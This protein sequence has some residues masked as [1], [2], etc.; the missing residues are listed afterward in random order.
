M[1]NYY[2]LILIIQF[3]ILPCNVSAIE[4]PEKLA[5]EASIVEHLN[6][7]VDLSRSFTDEFGKTVTIL[8]LFL[9]DRP[10]IIVPVYFQCPRLCNYTLDGVTKLLGDL[11]LVLGK[12]YSVAIVSFNSRETSLDA[13]KRATKYKNSINTSDQAKKA[14][15]F[16]TGTEENVQGIMHELGFSF[17]KDKEEFAH[18][19]VFMVLTPNGKISRYFYGIQYKPRDVRLALVEAA[20]G[21]IGSTLER[22]FLYCFHFDALRGKYT[23]VAMNL[24][25]VVSLSVLGILVATLIILKLK[26]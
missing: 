9:K 13:H 22:V 19:A 3:L 8:E 5:E 16:L 17:L 2:R 6:E 12:D 21:R 11:D 18:A 25:R 24:V 20:R 1:S 23:L 10:M 26:E 14:W 4:H 7:Q 15:H